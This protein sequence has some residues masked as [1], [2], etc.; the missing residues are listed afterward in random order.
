MPM[1]AG[2]NWRQVTI[3]IRALAIGEQSHGITTVWTLL[4]VC[5][6]NMVDHIVYRFPFII[7]TT[8]VAN[9]CTAPDHALFQQR[10]F[11]GS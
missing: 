9:F 1:G 11:N 7:A 4:T 8:V 3:A 10:K 6:Y 2:G 5:Y